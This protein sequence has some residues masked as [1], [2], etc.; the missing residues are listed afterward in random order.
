MKQY[1]KELK[2]AGLLAR[3]LKREI[4]NNDRAQ[5]M[6][7]LNR[8]ILHKTHKGVGVGVLRSTVQVWAGRGTRSTRDT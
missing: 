7:S 2:P 5:E 1:K 3:S 6:R 4:P 8:E